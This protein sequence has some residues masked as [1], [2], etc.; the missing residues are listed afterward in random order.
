MTEKQRKKKTHF[1]LRKYA[2]KVRFLELFFSL[3][4][5]LS[6]RGGMGIH[7]RGPGVSEI[8]YRSQVLSKT[9]LTHFSQNLGGSLNRSGSH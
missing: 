1:P 5:V 6:A 9:L 8:V 3:I 7:G 2:V 4:L